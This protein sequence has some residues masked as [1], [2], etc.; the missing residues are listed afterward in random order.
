MMRT[1]L[2]GC[3]DAGERRAMVRREMAQ[4]SEW[5]GLPGKSD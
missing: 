3:Y 1:P 5:P 4:L 2:S